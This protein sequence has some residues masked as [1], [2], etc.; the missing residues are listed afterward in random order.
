[1]G[2]QQ[3]TIPH[4]MTRSNQPLIGIIFLEN[5][6]EVVHYFVEDIQVDAAFATRTAQEALN[7]AGAWSDLDWN[8]MEEELYRIRHQN[9]PT[10]PLSL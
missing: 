2:E 3:D 8:Q 5:G 4:F 1:M 10:P 9:P 6:R 7:L